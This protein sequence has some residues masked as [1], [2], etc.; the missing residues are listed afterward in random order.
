MQIH[1]LTQPRSPIKEGVWDSLRAALSSDPRMDGM[2]LAQKEAYIKQ[3]DLVQ[4]VA[5]KANS[6]WGA[7]SAQLE[8]SITDPAQ[9]DQFKKRRNKTYENALRAFVQKN[10]LAG[11]PYDRLMNRAQIEALIKTMSLPGNS[12]PTVQTPLWQQMAQATSVSQVEAL[13]PAVDP[14]AKAI[15]VNKAAQSIQSSL[16]GTT[17]TDLRNIGQYLSSSRKDAWHV[18]SKDERSK[19]VRD[20]AKVLTG[21]GIAVTG[22]NPGTTPGSAATALASIAA[23]T[24]GIKTTGNPSL[25]AVLTSLGFTII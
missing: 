18:L 10:L 5:Y 8:N 16:R 24:P 21:M 7:Y 11:L 12:S 1:E 9:L 2:S 25:D 22:Y 4:D 23:S 6:A 17:A 20:V 14:S 13:A 15:N 3:G 19:V